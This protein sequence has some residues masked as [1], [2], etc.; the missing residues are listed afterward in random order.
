[1]SPTHLA[2]PAASTESLLAMCMTAVAEWMSHYIEAYSHGTC[3]ITNKGIAYSGPDGGGRGVPTDIA[4]GSTILYQNAWPNMKGS[5]RLLQR[6]TFDKIKW[7]RQ[8]QMQSLN[9]VHET[10]SHLGLPQCALA[11]IAS[12]MPYIMVFM[13]V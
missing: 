6:Q 1:M 5:C 9:F 12:L 7:Q 2:L 4:L 10:P 13:Y 11:W 8:P 3:I